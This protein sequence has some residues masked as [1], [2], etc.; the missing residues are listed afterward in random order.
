M[1]KRNDKRSHIYNFMTVTYMIDL[2]AVAASFD[3]K[4]SKF[5]I[6]LL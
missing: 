2:P 6:I 1:N 5:Y 4:L 3:F